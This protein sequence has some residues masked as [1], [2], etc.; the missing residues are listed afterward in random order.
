MKF[1][2][3]AL[4][5]IVVLI[6]LL[7]GAL[8]AIPYFFKDE[9]VTEVKN[10]VNENLNATVDFKDVD[11]SLLRNFPNVSINLQ[12]YSVTG[13]EQFD[14]VNLVSGT[15]L[16][17][18][19]DFW[20]AY[21]FGEVPLEIKSVSLDKPNV[22]VVVLENGQTN[23]DIVKSSGEES[24]ET[25][26]FQI[27]LNS[28][29]ITD[30]HIVYDD[31]LWDTYVE[32]SGLNHSGKGDFTQDVFDLDTQTDIAE[33]TTRSGG[34]TYLKKAHLNYEAGFNIDMPNSKYTLRENELIINDLQLNTD[35]WVGL[36]P[37]SDV[38][39]DLTFEAPQS[40][41]KSL[42]SMIPNAYIAG[43]ENVKA[44]GKFT[45]NGSAKG[46]YSASPES[47]PAFK[48]NLNIADGDVKYPD[49]PI[50]IT[51]IN[52]DVMIN[53]PSSILDKMQVDVSRFNLKVGDN[54]IEGFFK[55]KTPISDPDIDTKIKGK[56]DLGDFVRA[57]PLEGVETLNG[58]IDVDM[59]AKTKMST[60]DK[61]AYADVDMDGS[62]SIQ[63]MDYVADGLPAV[64]IDAMRL[65][66]TP[67]NLQISNFDMKLGK[68]DLS[69]KGKIDNVLAYFSPDATM[70]GDITIRSN[71]FYVDEWMAEEEP[72]AN[73]A[74]VS[75]QPATEEEVFDRFDF[76]VD[77]EIGKMDSYGIQ[78]SDLKIKGQATPNKLV[79]ENVSGQIGE[80]DFKSSGVLF[81]I[82]DYVFKNGTI[83]G[84]LK[85]TSNYMNLNQFMTTEEESVASDPVEASEPFVVPDQINIDVV[86]DMG[87]VIYDNLELRDVNGG[88]KIAD[89]A[90]TFENVTAKTLGGQ[91]AIK[92][93]YDTKDQEKP[94]FDFGLELANMDFQKAFNA[95][96]SFEKIAPIGKYIEGKFN[97]RFNMTSVLGKDLMPVYETLTSDG[98]LQTINGK[99]T[100]FAPLESV[101]KKL[102]VDAFKKIDIKNSKN[103]FVIKD[104]GVQLEEFDYVYEDIPMKIGGSHSI[105]GEDMDYYI[106]AKIPRE[107]IGKNPL[108]A[109][110]NSG[111]DLLSAK[112]SELGMSIDAGE[113]IN[114]RIGI[115]GTVADPKIGVQFV[116]QEGE[117]QTTQDKVAETVNDAVN[118]LAK[119]TKDV[120]QQELKEQTKNIKEDVK[121]ETKK[122][123]QSTIDS[124]KVSFKDQIDSLAT[125]KTKDAANE[126]KKAIEEETKNKLKDLNPFK[127]K[128]KNG[129]D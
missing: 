103:W 6:L 95:F 87:K 91:M 92:G 86:A 5:V 67:Q 15:S 19:V 30:G 56:L 73:E 70:K 72:L 128:K 98:F 122:I 96:N 11:I 32:I 34:V 27:Q 124:S 94:V 54:P 100:A 17:I 9:I 109:A 41:F 45:L 8:V 74:P 52:T 110:A 10:A 76:K 79:A 114:V 62:A 89:E 3:K 68:S 126:V 125:G 31:Q 53:S 7:V 80:S 71:Y 81:N 78:Y 65:F 60:V 35:G 36:T 115:T 18:A 4:I 75:S 118:D 99:I 58:V 61:G 66:F 24:T 28:Y 59:R 12:E 23:T 117:K 40:D 16:A 88:L 29:S 127:K 22:N 105:V 101:S 104:G 13:K 82:W 1:L 83:G 48:V 49:L 116:G 129:G 84:N 111:L 121:E 2:K 44:G 50:G 93:G 123:L 77:S 43:Y 39:M 33:L 42:L 102:K 97:T 64:R 25:T 14:G 113:F 21:N 90:V 107:K 119:E 51:G 69:G 63:K 57:Y 108:G 38:E 106:N 47:Y 85:L 20:S 120:A 46:K 26:P 37:E 55:L 112:A